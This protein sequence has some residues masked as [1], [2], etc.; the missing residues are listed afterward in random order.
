MEV[1]VQQLSGGTRMKK[2]DL[3]GKGKAREQ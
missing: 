2:V 3:K 1:I